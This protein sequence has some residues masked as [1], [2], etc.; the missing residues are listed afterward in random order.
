LT[1]ILV[2]APSYTTATAATQTVIRVAAPA[3]L[4]SPSA[5]QVSATVDTTTITTTAAYP[6][7]PSAPITP[8]LTYLGPATATYGAPVALV[9]LLADGGGNPLPGRTL[10]FSFDG[11]P[12]TATTDQTGVATAGVTPLDAPSS[13]TATVAFAGDKGATAVQTTAAIT[14][15]R[16]PTALTY[17]GP[18]PGTTAPRQ[19]VTATL[20]DSVDGSAVLNAPVHLALGSAAAD[21]TTDAT[22]MATATL[23]LNAD[24]SSAGLPLQISYGGDG[25]YLPA[26]ISV[27]ASLYLP[28]TYGAVVVRHAPALNGRVEGTVRQLRGENVTLNS[29]A[30]V[31]GD[32]LVPGS[33]TV[34]INGSPAFSGTMSGA[35][36]AQ[37]SGY[38]VGLNSGARLAHLVTRTDP[39]S[40]SAVTAPPTPAGTRD[41]TINTAGQGIGDPTTLRNLTLNGNVGAVAV[42]PGA[43]GQFIGNSGTSFVLG[44]AGSTHPA[45]YTLQSLTFNGP[46]AVRLAGPVVLTLA[47]GVS[48]NGQ[49]GTTA[50]PLWLTLNVA[51]GGVTL[52]SG[53]ALYGV[54][55]APN[56]MVIVNNSAVLQGALYADGLTVNSGGIVR[57]V[58]AP[59]GYGAAPAL[60][61]MQMQPATA[62]PGQGLDVTLRVTNT[63]GI[64]ATAVTAQEGFIGTTPATGTAGLGT[65]G[66]GTSATTT[67]HQT[68]QAIA[69]RGAGETSGAYLTRLAAADGQTL[70]TSGVITYADAS[71][72]GYAP[73][74]VS[75]S[76]MLA[77]PRLSL[78][79]TVPTCAI[80][81]TRIP[82]TVRVTNLGRALATNAAVTV[83]FADG[84]VGRLPIATLAP[85]ATVTGT[86]TWTVPA[87]P[88]RGAA[89]ATADYQARLAAADGATYT[90]QGGVTWQD[91]AGNSYGPVDASA[92]VTG[93][94]PVVAISA[95]TPTTLVPGHVV[96]T[97]LTLTNTGSLDAAPA[98]ARVTNP[99]GSVSTA[100]APVP[101][102]RTVTLYTTWLVPALP[103]ATMQSTGAYLSRLAA[104]DGG[105]SRFATSLSWADQAGTSYGPIAGTG[106][107][108]GEPLPIV[109]LAVSGPPAARGDDAISYT[110]NLT[111]TGSA[112]A[113]AE[114]LTL[115]MPDGSLRVPAVGP[116]AAGA[117]TQVTVPY[118]V[119]HIQTSGDTTVRARVTWQDDTQN[120][121]GPVTAT[122]TTSMTALPT[123]TP[124]NTR[125]ATATPTATATNSPTSTPTSIP[126][127]TPTNTTT[128][129]PSGTPTNTLQPSYQTNGL[130]VYVGYA[131]TLRPNP[132]V[133][134]P[135]RGA[136]NTLFIGDGGAYDSGAIRLDNTTD[137]PIAVK[138]VS[139]YFPNHN[140]YNG[141]TIN[142]WGSF[143][144]QPH[145]SAILAETNGANFDTSDYGL[146]SIG[147]GN[148]AGPDNNPPHLTITLGDGT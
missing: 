118:T 107:G 110:V 134:V 48:F 89:E 113:G 125:T 9:A 32:L 83:T 15:G 139:T 138:D 120:A 126:T 30:V 46:G 36:S 62:L 64:S 49:I 22:G 21:A 58:A 128:S 115:I 78:G 11:Q 141:Q 74:P 92:T 41:V 35:G 3:P 5:S 93:R 29:G 116:L 82:Y 38:T 56:G 28:T 103:H 97:T 79:L 67:F 54:V 148:P 51:S 102:G 106:G 16:A 96:T 112:D 40:L 45:V 77:L 23:T 142:L 31:T 13:I 131:D 33:P 109:A 19:V 145:G 26:R 59:P 12:V 75:S 94:L 34:Q 130:N 90:A 111:N 91:A 25:H 66:G 57:G 114:S 70:T 69:S 65:I 129:Q 1:L 105:S 43:Y 127:V 52:N 55:R 119:S 104:I 99:D 136:P 147:C 63:T 20:M 14:I 133:P 137:A 60:A 68:T 86:L 4:L 42:P 146:P 123:D 71:G 80:P 61:A 53:S 44:V 81:G 50:I 85:S 124:T 135:W 10:S 88:A 72:Q 95:Q 8:T 101:A 47:N 122:A 108:A 143:T 140:M 76:S 117:S 100:Q 144:V 39:V 132:N 2:M 27:P 87:V 98:T 37:P 73:L 24:Q 18:L 17:T 84:S 121:F 7:G 6:L